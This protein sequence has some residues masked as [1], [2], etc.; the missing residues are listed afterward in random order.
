MLGLRGATSNHIP[1]N[2]VHIPISDWLPISFSQHSK[3]NKILFN[4]ILSELPI[5]Y[6][7]VPRTYTR[8]SPPHSKHPCWL[9]KVWTNCHIL[10]LTWI[11]LHSSVY[12]GCVPRTTLKCVLKCADSYYWTFNVLLNWYHYTIKSKIIKVSLYNPTQ[13]MSHLSILSQLCTK[14]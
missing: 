2:Y 6:S 13:F 3:I 4:Y 5:T 7:H 1:Q 10:F 12:Y 9:S 11:I 14:I 8:L